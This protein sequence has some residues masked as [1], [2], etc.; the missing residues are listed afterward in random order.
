MSHYSSK[1]DARKLLRRL[2]DHDVLFFE[3]SGQSFIGTRGVGPNGTLIIDIRGREARLNNGETITRIPWSKIDFVCL[4][5]HSAQDCEL[6]INLGNPGLNIG[7]LSLFVN[8]W[9]RREL[10]YDWVKTITERFP[11]D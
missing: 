3:Y 2:P 4:P 9:E 8:S 10:G 11:P 6:K 1:R 5:T 7:D